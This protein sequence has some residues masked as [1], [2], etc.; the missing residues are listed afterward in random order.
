MSYAVFTSFDEGYYDTAAVMVS[1]LID[2]YSGQEALQLYCLVPE[3]LHHKEDSFISLVGSPSNVSIKFVTAKR[4]RG[5]VNSRLVENDD[6]EVEWITTSAFHRIFISSEFPDI[7]KAIYIDPDIIILR[8]IQPILDYPLHNKIIAHI[9]LSP[10]EYI[11]K[12]TNYFNNG[13]YITDLNYWRE[14]GLEG[15]M[16]NDILHDRVSKHGEQDLMNKYF[17]DCV[18]HLPR[19]MNLF[20]Y[21]DHSELLREATPDPIIVHF[22]GPLK[23]WKNHDVETRWTNIWRDRYRKLFGFDI[24]STEGYNIMYQF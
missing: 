2:N 16:I 19:T 21:Q 14:Q 12:D 4:Y 6:I 18:S 24:S 22:L 1:M 5:L 11:D 15:K 9:E 7:D 10:P 8:D 13:V 23:P 17:K 20:S 3:E